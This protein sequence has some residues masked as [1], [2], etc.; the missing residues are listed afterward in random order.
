M[1]SKFMV[2]TYVLFNQWGEECKDI[3]INNKILAFG[4]DLFIHRADE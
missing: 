4:N 3:A 2:K 1:V